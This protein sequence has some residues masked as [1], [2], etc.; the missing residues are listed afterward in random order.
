MIL[1]AMALALTLCS[2]LDVLALG[3]DTAQGLGL[4]VKGTRLVLL[5]LSALLA[6]AAVS[7]AGLVGFVGL[8]VPHA[9]R[10]LVGSE[11]RRLLPLCALGGATARGLLGARALALAAYVAVPAVVAGAGAALARALGLLGLAAGARLAAATA[12]AAGRTL[13]LARKALARRR[14]LAALGAAVVVA[15]VDVVSSAH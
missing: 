1:L 10:A 12:C 3:E 13:L 14:G 2:E 9:A 7:F 15:A 11:S 5:L 4:G 6:G 8:I